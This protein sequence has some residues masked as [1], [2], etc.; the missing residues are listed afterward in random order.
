M[1][2]GILVLK[3]ILQY[4]LTNYNLNKNLKKGFP[5]SYHLI[6]TSVKPIKSKLALEI[7]SFNLKLTRLSRPQVSFNN[8]NVN[9]AP[10]GEQDMPPPKM[11]SYI[12]IIILH[13]YYFELNNIFKSFNLYI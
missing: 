13:I 7:H 10:E 3:P 1:N 8:K 11:L 12:F 9:K 2:H 5:F 6:P 4:V